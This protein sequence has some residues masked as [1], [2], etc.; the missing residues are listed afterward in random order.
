MSKNSSV[1]MHKTIQ[2]IALTLIVF[3]PLSATGSIA[4]AAAHHTES[5]L[6][7]VSIETNLSLQKKKTRVP[8]TKPTSTGVVKKKTPTPS[9]MTEPGGGEPP[10]RN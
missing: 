8:A 3:S 9:P 2:T 10:A 7:T 4:P 6:S 1:C 5:H